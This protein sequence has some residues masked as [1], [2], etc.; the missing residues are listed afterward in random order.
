MAQTKAV[1]ANSMN[2]WS[3]TAMGIGAMVGAGI[4]ALLG[5]AAL[6][7]GE[8]TY[9]AFIL[10]GVV[11]LLSGYS[12]A[13]LGVRYPDAGGLSTFFDRGFG[14][15]KLAGCL[16]LIYLLTLAVCV[17]LLAKA[18]GSYAAALL[19]IRASPVWINVFAS[20][21][22]VLLLFLNV[23]GSELVGK[24]E[25]LLVGIKLLILATL[26]VAGGIG[27][28][29]KAP[30]EHLHPGILAVV[31]SVGF[32]FLAYAGF[33][34][35]TNAAANVKQPQTT[36]PRSIYLAI[37]TVIVVYVGLA[38]VVLGNLTPAALAQHPNTA[39]AEAAMPVLGHIGY[40]IVS[41]GALLATASGI[42]AYLF[43]SLK[44]SKSMAAA[45]QLPT[46]FSQILWHKG[47]RGYLLGAAAV[48]VAINTLDLKALADIASATFLMVYFAVHVA[49]WRL[50]HETTGSRPIIAAGI[51]TMGLVLAG[52]LW[53]TAAAQPWS[54]V[55]IGILIA[56]SWTI[57]VMLARHFVGSKA[58]VR[59]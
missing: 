37:A 51:I 47:S 21:I 7:A 26:M 31:G 9:V 44:I 35:M 39:V 4:F 57:E 18:F 17:A 10:A 55:F 28:T 41:A 11:A 32:T 1:K 22:T 59:S 54:V 40:V 45:G 46:M 34:M 14:T 50:I 20:G 25:I 19:G 6:V 23:A 56:G 12:F 33:G 13:K 52:F 49:H 36:I 30:S 3:V 43:G 48:L 8:E 24:A 58:Q 16:S 38:I 27:M 29:H 15:G 5:Q 42:N 2:L 53:T